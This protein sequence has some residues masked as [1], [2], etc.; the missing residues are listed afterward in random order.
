MREQAI[1]SKHVNYAPNLLLDQ[2][3]GYLDTSFAVKNVDV[4]SSVEQGSCLVVD[5]EIMVY[6]S[7]NS[8][9]KVL[10]VKRGALDT[11]PAFHTA[12]AMAFFM[13]HF[14]HMTQLHMS[15]VK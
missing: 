10:T 5:N 7:Y 12:N 4:I 11:H 8:L 1:S 3:I 13:M 9:T 2:N 6:Q 14:H 15:M